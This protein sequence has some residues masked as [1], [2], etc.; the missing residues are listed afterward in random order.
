[1]KGGT[2]HAVDLRPVAAGD[3]SARVGRPLALP[4]RVETEPADEIGAALETVAAGAQSP[5]EAGTDVDAAGHSDPERC[6]DAAGAGEDPIEPCLDLQRLL[7]DLADGGWRAN[8]C[9]RKEDDR[10]R[11]RSRHIALRRRSIARA[12]AKWQSCSRR[13][14]QWKSHRSWRSNRRSAQAARASPRA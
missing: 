6:F 2:R 7:R 3:S 4:E 11:A 9:E 1:M 13:S 10:Q 12:R 14:M 8:Q 5:D